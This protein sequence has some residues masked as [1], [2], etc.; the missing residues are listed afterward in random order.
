MHKLLTLTGVTLLGA[1]ILPLTANA[2]ALCSGNAIRNVIEAAA[3]AST[4]NPDNVLTTQ[5][6][7]E[8][9]SAQVGSKQGSACSRAKTKLAK[10]ILPALK[11]LGFSPSAI[12]DFNTQL[13]AL[14]CAPG[15]EPTPNPIPSPS[16]GTPLANAIAQIH[17]Q[18]PKDTMACATRV[19]CILSAVRALHDSQGLSE[20]DTH[21]LLR[22]LLEN[23]DCDHLP[24]PP[25]PTP[26]SLSTNVAAAV[27][28]LENGCTCVSTQPFGV[29]GRCVVEHGQQLK[30]SF[31]PETLRT[32]FGQAISRVGECG[33]PGDE[34]HA[35]PP[36][37]PQP[38]PTP[39]GE[40][41]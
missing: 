33:I 19:P 10:K 7:L 1:A 37:S 35:S 4:C 29:Y 11:L 22:A 41:H 23:A 26:P 28:A 9:V 24:T 18:C 14:P 17:L 32:A 25:T 16:P 27:A 8:L 39:P 20:E 30:T 6:V 13:A 5:E 12:S 31:A 15:V 2:D 21:R 3:Q 36:P 40:H 38:T 34:P